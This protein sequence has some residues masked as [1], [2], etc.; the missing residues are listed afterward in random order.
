M[1]MKKPESIRQS[2]IIIYA[3]IVASA[4]VSLIDR[5]I[6]AI[7]PG[8]FAFQLIVYGFLFMIPYK[9]GRRSNPARYVYVV[10]A[11]IAVLLM[12][13]GGVKVPRLDLILS[14]IMI[15]VEIYVSWTLFQPASSRWFTGEGDDGEKPSWNTP[16]ERRE[17]K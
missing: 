2:E 12:V 3:C 13:G 7:G 5:W 11:V 14:V 6:G 16:N 1:H 17:P 10:S 15:P 9:L 4:L 8:E